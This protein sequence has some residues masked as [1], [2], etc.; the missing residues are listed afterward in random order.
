MITPSLATLSQQTD[1]KDWDERLDQA[2][3]GINNTFHRATGVA[4]FVLLFNYRSRN[5]NGDVVESAIQD[6][7]DWN[8]IVRREDTI[9]KIRQDQEKQRIRYNAKRSNAE[10]Y[11]PG[12]LVV[13]EREAAATGDSR[14]LQP[15]FRG[16]YVV[17]KKLQCD[18]YRVED[19]PEIQR[20][21]RRYVNTVPVD[22]LKRWCVDVNDGVLSETDGDAHGD[23]PSNGSSSEEDTPTSR[24]PI[25]T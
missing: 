24:R 2:Q 16:P 17:T 7:L 11:G 8:I 20:T 21:Q 19:V 22:K 4:P 14:K 12:D 15:R 6:V 1:S 3:W 9:E 23:N 13:I 5:P 10:E 18:R 25:R